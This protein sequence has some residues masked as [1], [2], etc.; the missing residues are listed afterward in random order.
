MEAISYLN[1]TDPRPEEVISD[2]DR[3]LR[4]A[5]TM[6]LRIA[7]RAGQALAGFR[8]QGRVQGRSSGW[9]VQG[10]YTYQSGAALG[11]G[12]AICSGQ[13]WRMSFCRASQRTIGPLVQHRRGFNRN[14]A[15]SLPRTS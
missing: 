13:T 14:S 12:N 1:P 10:I 8:Q 4:L 11:F 2:Q 15:S 9:Q 5:V 7:V 6:D 3:T